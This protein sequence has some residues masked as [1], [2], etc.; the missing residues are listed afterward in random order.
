LELMAEAAAAPES[1]QIPWGSS[2]EGAAPPSPQQQHF[3]WWGRHFGRRKNTER[4]ATS[5]SNGRAAEV[6]LES[7]AARPSPSAGVESPID[8]VSGVRMTATGVGESDAG[9][10]RKLCPSCIPR[11][12]PK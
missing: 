12:I 11:V 6:D 1:E 9:G 10:D 4:F 8:G 5:D 3:G 2:R 7:S